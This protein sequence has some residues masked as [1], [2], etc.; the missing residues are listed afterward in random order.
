MRLASNWVIGLSGE[1]MLNFPIYVGCM[2]GLFTESGEGHQR[3]W[4]APKDPVMEEKDKLVLKQQWD[5]WW[6]RLV[7]LLANNYAI[8]SHQL[9]PGIG[10]AERHFSDIEG[11][12]LRQ[13]C[14]DSW[15][16]F[17]EWWNMPAGGQM[18]MYYW[19]GFPRVN[20][21]VEEYE[22]MVGRKIKPFSLSV[23]LVYAGITAP[24]EPVTD[25]IIMP[26]DGPYLI[27]KDWWLE[28]FK[29]RY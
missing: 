23:N 14:I 19:E 20:K 4:P 11:D 28:R 9:G 8:R 16:A 24:I 12:L 29:Q 27:S 2:Y 13:C 3:F 26:I 18:A 7:M 15:P 10:L 25:Y 21:Y 6:D 5:K 1:Y 17:I 22:R